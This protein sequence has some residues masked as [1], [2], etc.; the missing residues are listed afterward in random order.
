MG[1]GERVEGLGNLELVG[2]HAALVD[3]A[4]GAVG[5]GARAPRARVGALASVQLDVALKEQIFIVK[6]INKF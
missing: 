3:A 2:M 6:K 5:E 1:G 4:V